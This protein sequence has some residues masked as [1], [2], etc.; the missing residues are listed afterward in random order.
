MSE[1][2]LFLPLPCLRSQNLACLSH[3]LL[4]SWP[5]LQYPDWHFLVFLLDLSSGNNIMSTS[6][7]WL[8]WYNEK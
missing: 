2:L 6:L 3:G 4:R 5:W 8:R 1:R 7:K